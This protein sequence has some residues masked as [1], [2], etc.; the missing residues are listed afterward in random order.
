M[1]MGSGAVISLSTKQKVNACSSTEAELVA[2]DDVIAKILWTKKFIEWQGFEVKFNIIYQ[3]NTSTMKF[4]MNGKTS[5]GKRTRHF[6][7]NLFYVTNLVER[8]EATIEYCTPDEM[9]ADFFTKPLFGN[10][11]GKDKEKEHE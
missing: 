7:I 6:D 3:D 5:C 8:K 9:M 10:K 4:E 1:T 11:F 2:V